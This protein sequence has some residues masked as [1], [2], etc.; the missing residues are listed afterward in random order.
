[1]VVSNALGKTGFD[2]QQTSAPADRPNNLW[3]P[4][5]GDY[6][7]RGAFDRQAR[8]TSLELKASFGRRWIGAAW[9]RRSRSF[10]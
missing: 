9:G 5:K 6:G 10:A 7:A 2:L 3:E 8:D 1:M 4:V